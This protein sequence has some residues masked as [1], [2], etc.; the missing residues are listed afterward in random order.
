M[1]TQSVLAGELQLGQTL[2]HCIRDGKK[3]EFDLLLAMLS[4]DVT[5]QDQF[6][7][8]PIEE[9]KL[10]AQSLREEFNVPIPQTLKASSS[11]ENEY[12]LKLGKIANEE[13][14]LTARFHHCLQP[15][16]LDFK[17]NMKHGIASEL[18]NSL[19]PT[20]AKRFTKQVS[21]IR[22]EIIEIDKLIAAQKNYDANL[23]IA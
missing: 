23:I 1:Q 18:Y 19:S 21:E 6:S 4:N 3:S 13:G 20:V 14:L 11:S 9:V 10:P 12:S 17:T 16:A 5:E 15:D 2:N 7:L 22:P 8:N